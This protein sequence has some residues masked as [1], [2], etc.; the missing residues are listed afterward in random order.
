M[1]PERLLEYHLGTLTF[2]TSESL[3]PILLYI[4][5]Q[6]YDI[7]PPAPYTYSGTYTNSSYSLPSYTLLSY[8]SYSL[9]SPISYLVR[10]VV[11]VRGA[12][13]AERCK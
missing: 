2:K 13:A 7:F 11:A 9:S 8:I 1:G 5:P 4:I 10:P 12:A 6:V 3:L